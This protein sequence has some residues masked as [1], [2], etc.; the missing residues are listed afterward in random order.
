MARINLHPYQRSAS[1]CRLPRFVACIMLAQA[2]GMNYHILSFFLPTTTMSNITDITFKISNREDYGRAGSSR[3]RSAGQIPAV[4]YGKGDLLHFSIEDRTFRSVMRAS[5]GSISLVELE[6]NA[7]EKHLALLKEIQVNKVKDSILHLDFIHVARGQELETKVPV[8]LVGEAPGVRT[9][10]GILENHISEVTVRCRPSNLPKSLELDVSSLGL[11]QSLQIKD[12][13][14]VQ[15]VEILGDSD[16]NVITCVGSASGRA[17]ASES[18]ATDSAD[19]E[20]E[21]SGAD[22]D[23]SEESSAPDS[24]E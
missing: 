1:L 3:L 19:S 20:E 4:L 18:A 23:A 17:D 8:V 15:D 11:G 6:S 9:E 5:G 7:G 24:S 14:P 22:E 12:L 21:L 10:G 2:C 16:A 13:T